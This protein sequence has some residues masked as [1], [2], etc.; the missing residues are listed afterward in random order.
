M[1]DCITD[2]DP[3][4][5]DIIKDCG[6]C[7]CAFDNRATEAEKEAPVQELMGM[8][9]EMM[10]SDGGA[11]FSDT[12]YKNMEK[13]LKKRTEVPKKIYTDPLNKEIKQVEKEYTHKS[14]QEQEEKIKGLK[15][16]YDEQIKNLREE[17][18][19]SILLEDL[20]GIMR[21]FSKI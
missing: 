11:Y 5:K 19:R 17:A 8:V 12:I 1:Y 13:S 18:E 2:V 14:Q 15:I 21:L 6:N 9:G 3:I 4:L 16:K 7:F 20:N 10:W